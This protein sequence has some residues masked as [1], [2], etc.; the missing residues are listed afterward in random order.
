MFCFYPC[1]HQRYLN[2]LSEL[3][4]LY[5][6]STINDFLNENP[7]EMNEKKIKY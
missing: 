2:L 3:K 4:Y 1:V 6:Y 7:S 5:S